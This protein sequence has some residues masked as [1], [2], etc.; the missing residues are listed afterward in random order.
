MANM[1]TA[2][3]EFTRLVL[4]QD[5]Q[6]PETLPNTDSEQQVACVS[7]NDYD[8]RMGIR[9]SAIFVI[10]VGSTLGQLTFHMQRLCLPN[11]I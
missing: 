11:S 7:K 4:R 2:A 5:T 1:D 10:L 3:I 6:A 9:I 8:G